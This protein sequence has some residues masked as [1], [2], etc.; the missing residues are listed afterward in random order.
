MLE[1][2]NGNVSVYVE[3]YLMLM[4]AVYVMEAVKVAENAAV[5]KPK[6]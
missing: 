3:T 2:L 5:R 6:Q 1:N 4:A